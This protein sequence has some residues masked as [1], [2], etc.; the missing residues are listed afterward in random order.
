MGRTAH[1]IVPGIWLLVPFLLLAPAPQGASAQLVEADG[2]VD[3]VAAIV[4][5]SAILLSQVLQRERQE[6]AAG[7][8]LPEPGT[9]ELEEYRGVI[10]GGLVDYMLMLTAASRD[11]LLQV[12]DARVEDSLQIHMAGIESNFVDRAAM[13]QALRSE[14]MTVQNFREMIRAQIHQGQLVDLYVR[15]RVSGEAV[16]ISDEEVR[17]AFETGR[18]GLQRRP[19]IVTF[20]Q[21]VLP[22]EPSDSA[23]QAVKALLEG[24]RER[25]MAGEDFAELASEY[26]MGPSGA[27]GGDLGWFRRGQWVDEFDETAFGLLEGAISPVI[28][29][30]FGYHIILVERVRFSERKGRHILIRPE[31]GAAER[32]QARALAE[33]LVERAKTEDFQGLI[34]QF[35]KSVMPDSI[36]IFQRQ[37]ASVLPAYFSALTLGETGEVLSPIQF[38]TDTGQEVFA[39]V[40]VLERKPEGE[41]TFEE[42]EPQLRARLV[43][44]KRVEQHLNVLRSRTYIDIKG[45]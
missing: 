27:D 9:P 44:Q 20:R 32:I 35:H 29:T 12:D 5:D 33:E 31:G 10:L 28:E 21:L 39:L 43:Q 18:A 3:R 14:G 34:D 7:F 24:L 30:E 11:T 22:V 19:A 16:E 26:S 4:G 41:V 25:A 17:A 45:T 8:Q 37:I 1:S 42:Y 36:D 6:R 40:K 13:E 23:H 2:V 38:T 15:T